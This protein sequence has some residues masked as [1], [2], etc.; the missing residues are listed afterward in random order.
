MGL[1]K[2]LK[3]MGIPTSTL[4]LS[5]TVPRGRL[6]VFSVRG[7]GSQLCARGEL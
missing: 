5:C 3:V 4:Y 6:G 2:L 7:G 1:E